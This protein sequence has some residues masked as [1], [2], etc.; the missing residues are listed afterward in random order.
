MG[1]F[2][3]GLD[4]FVPIDDAFPLESQVQELHLSL[5]VDSEQRYVARGLHLVPTI[6]RRFLERVDLRY[7]ATRPA[8]LETRIT[9][10]DRIVLGQGREATELEFL[11]LPREE[12]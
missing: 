2:P 7:D 9:S 10:G 6:V 12:R 1:H 3:R 11:M 4:L 5:A 8:P